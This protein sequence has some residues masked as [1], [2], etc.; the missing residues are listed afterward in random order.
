MLAGILHV[1]VL[2][3]RCSG[4][5]AVQLIAKASQMLISTTTGEIITEGT[6]EQV[7]APNAP[8]HLQG[9]AKLSSGDHD[10]LR[11]PQRYM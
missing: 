4:C 7:T 8:R 2:A 11:L 10:H 3:V 9:L 1:M 6:T 5:S